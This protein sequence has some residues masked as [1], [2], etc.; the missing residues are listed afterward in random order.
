MPN[1]DTKVATETVTKVG[2]E[3]RAERDAELATK[4]V[5]EI[6]TEKK[7]ESGIGPGIEAAMPGDAYDQSDDESD[8]HGHEDDEFASHVQTLLSTETRNALALLLVRQQG[9]QR[10][11][12]PVGIIGPREATTTQ[13]D[14]AA[15]IA[16]CLACAGVALICGGKGGVMEAAARGAQKGKGLIVGLLPEDDANAA[17][18][19]LSVA[20]P[21][22][23]GI[24]R[25]AL[26]ARAACCLVAVG[27]GLGTTSEMA[28]GLQ[29]GK[30]TLTIADAPTLPGA[31]PF[32]T[33]DALIASLCALLL[34]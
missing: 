22:G 24:M 30:P 28:L 25:N 1:T 5:T 29:W 19:Y 7:T 18:R 23:M 9:D 34:A 10:H 8:G 14:S 15:F 13:L 17:N 2:P 33:V 6:D 12:T 11:L 21:T 4:L 31:Q 27:G 26:I 20:V 32:E 16:Y 3:A